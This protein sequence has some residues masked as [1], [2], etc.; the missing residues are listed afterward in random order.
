M[1]AAG[2]FQ[3]KKGNEL[4]REP[5]PT[6]A[7]QNPLKIPFLLPYRDPAAAG[8]APGSRTTE[9]S[10]VGTWSQ[11]GT[12]AKEGICNWWRLPS[13]RASAFWGKKAYP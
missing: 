5:A 7:N 1:T 9:G 8:K 10:T 2:L 3:D 4:P 6:L 13:L 11:Q 12:D